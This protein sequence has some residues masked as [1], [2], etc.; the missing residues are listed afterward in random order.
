M[1]CIPLISGWLEPYVDTAMPGLR[2]NMLQLQLLGDLMFVTSFLL[3]GDNFWEK[4]R[5][6][7]MIDTRV[8]Y[9]DVPASGA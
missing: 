6:L 8:A 9:L 7:F 1:F 3:L 2:P 4:L 5:A